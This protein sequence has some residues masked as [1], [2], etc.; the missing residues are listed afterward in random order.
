MSEILQSKLYLG[1]DAKLDKASIKRVMDLGGWFKQGGPLQSR[2]QKWKGRYNSMNGRITFSDGKSIW[3]ASNED[4]RKIEL[5]WE[6]GFDWD[7]GMP[8][9]PLGL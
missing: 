3:S 8:C 7:V 1:E 9:P 5:L 6:L 4:K 2:A